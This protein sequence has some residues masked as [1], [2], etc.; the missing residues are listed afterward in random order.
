M[1]SIK[2]ALLQGKHKRRSNKDE[3]SN[4]NDVF[5]HTTVRIRHARPI[6]QVKHCWV[7]QSTLIGDVIG[8]ADA[9]Y[10]FA[11]FGP[12]VRLGILLQTFLHYL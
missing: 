10:V 9:E 2:I 3:L 12:F 8:T 5:G 1:A 6:C 4:R 11:I 7:C